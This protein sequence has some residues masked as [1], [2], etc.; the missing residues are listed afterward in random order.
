MNPDNNNSNNNADDINIDDLFGASSE[1]KTPENK[2]QKPEEKKEAPPALDAATIQKAIQDGIQQGVKAV[3]SVGSRQSEVDSYL[4]SE[5][6]KIYSQYSDKIKQVA[7]SPQYAHLSP[8]R[9]VGL[10]L[11]SKMATIGAQT[12]QNADNKANENKGGAQGGSNNRNADPGEKVSA[13]GMNKDD[14]ENTVAKAK[15]GV[16]VEK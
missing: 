9:I 6:G 7:T 10:V 16:F 12:K 5:E 3:T 13:W 11:G 4:N 2:E 15:A 1:N 14:F 8:D